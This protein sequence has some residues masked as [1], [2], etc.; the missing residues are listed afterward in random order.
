MRS[1]RRTSRTPLATLRRAGTLAVALAGASIS[2]GA[3]T[4]QETDSNPLNVELNKMETV[5]DACRVYLVFE[6]GTGRTFTD[7]TLDLVMF[8]QD[9]G[10]LNRLAVN[11]G[12]LDEGKTRVKLFDVPG[13]DC[14]RIGRILVNDV[15][16]CEGPGGE[17]DPATCTAFTEP[18]SRIG[19]DFIK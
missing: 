16:S 6:N 11:A 7:Y 2:A 19:T 4:A 8:A 14:A 5:G 12:R 10:I 17:G 1:I 15:M 3:V 9:G 13:T 18:S